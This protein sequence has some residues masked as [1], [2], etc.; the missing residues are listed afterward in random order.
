MSPVDR[1]PFERVEE[2]IAPFNPC[3]LDG[4]QDCPRGAGRAR[5]VGADSADLIVL[6]MS[7]S[8]VLT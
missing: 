3:R 8:D 6:D 2:K 5:A 4:R 1:Q 7:L